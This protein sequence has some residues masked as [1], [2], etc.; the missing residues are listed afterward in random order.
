MQHSSNFLGREIIRSVG[1]WAQGKTACLTADTRMVG[2][3]NSSMRDT[4]GWHEAMTNKLLTDGSPVSLRHAALRGERAS[5]IRGC[6]RSCLYVT[7]AGTS[8]LN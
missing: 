6:T 3:T 4:Y 2:T 7:G 5:P 1:N 8:I